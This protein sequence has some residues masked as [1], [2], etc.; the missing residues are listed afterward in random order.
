MLQVIL[1]LP[2]DDAQIPQAILDILNCFCKA[3][4]LV[5]ISDISLKPKLKYAACFN[6]HLN[7]FTRASSNKVKIAPIT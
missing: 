2:L 4:Y 5:Y 6:N 7:N 1:L 3:L